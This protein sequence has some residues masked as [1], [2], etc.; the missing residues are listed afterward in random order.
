PHVPWWGVRLVAAAAAAPV[1]LPHEAGPA[2]IA[3]VAVAI[4]VLRRVQ[5]P[6]RSPWTPRAA[7]LI[8]TL[9]LA[10]AATGA[11]RAGDTPP[12]TSRYLYFPAVVML[13]LACE[14]L[15]GVEVRRR[16]LVVA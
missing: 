3:V 8:A 7:G 13:L 6:G 14:M 5:S 16:A 4:V 1:G 11:A 15:A 9:V 12:T 10:V 2:V